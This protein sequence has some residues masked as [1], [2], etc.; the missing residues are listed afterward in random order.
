MPLVELIYDAECPNV[1]EAREQLVRAFEILDLSPQWKE[2]SS[3]DP[4]IPAHARNYGSPTILVAGQDVSGVGK[5][6]GTAGCRVYASSEGLRGVPT[7]EA[8]VSVLRRRTRPG[9]GEGM[10]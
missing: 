5:L 7:V 8:I 10:L 4:E 2:W 6:D 1:P 9:G 3:E